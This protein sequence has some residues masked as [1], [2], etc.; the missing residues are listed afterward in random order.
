MAKGQKQEW[1]RG[2][3]KTWA[4]KRRVLKWV[5]TARGGE[6]VGQNRGLP[7]KE[8]REVFGEKNRMGAKNEDGK[9]P[10]G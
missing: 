5:Q 2:I 7:L 10:G 1:Q 6:G 8:R 9:K 3:S 4:G